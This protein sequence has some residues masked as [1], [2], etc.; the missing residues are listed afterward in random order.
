M[1][2]RPNR[3]G[4]WSRRRF[5][6]LV[7]VAS[8]F[9]AAPAIA[10]TAKLSQAE[11]RL[12]FYH[13]HTGESL[14][15]VYWADGGYLTESLADID[16]ILRDFR[17]GEATRID[18]KLLD[19]LHAVSRKVEANEP[20]QI[21]SGYRSPATNDMLRKKGRGGVAKRSYHMRGMAID[22]RLEDRGLLDLH[23]AALAVRRGGVG[24]YR[25][26]GFIHV[27]VG[28]VRRW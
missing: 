12:S 11:R 9:I 2:H 19:L 23:K 7:G 20:F 27:D 14:D 28:P 6:S 17:S 15:A 4:V 5:L 8:S 13:L 26:S 10:H 22:V 18:R 1:K 16:H 25:N 21:I 3:E 24:L